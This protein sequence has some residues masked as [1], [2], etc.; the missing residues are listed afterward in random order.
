[1]GF[2]DK[3]CKKVDHNENEKKGYIDAYKCALKKI[4]ELTKYINKIDP[5]A[6]IVFHISQTGITW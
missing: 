1:M 3:N 5:N 6:F 2:Y 4:I